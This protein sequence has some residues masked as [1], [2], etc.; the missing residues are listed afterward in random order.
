LGIWW[1][2]IYRRFGGSLSSGGFIFLRKIAENIVQLYNRPMTG[3]SSLTVGGGLG[4]TI[5]TENDSTTPKW[6]ISTKKMTE[7]PDTFINT[8]HPSI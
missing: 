2:W 4:V 5:P 6:K 7:Q 1:D 3:P 8:L